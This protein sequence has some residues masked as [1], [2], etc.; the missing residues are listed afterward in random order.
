[1]HSDARESIWEFLCTFDKGEWHS[2]LDWISYSQGSFLL[3]EG[4]ETRFS[5]AFLPG[6]IHSCPPPSHFFC[7]V[8]YALLQESK[9]IGFTV[10]VTLTTG[11]CPY[12]ECK[13]HVKF[14][15]STA[16]PSYPALSA[17]FFRKLQYLVTCIPFCFY[18]LGWS[19]HL[20]IHHFIC[21][22]CWHQCAVLSVCWPDTCSSPACSS[23]WRWVGC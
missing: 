11:V 8:P 1:M 13:V 21:S 19:N 20:I 10:C 9:A 16:V 4:Q 7:S 6:H 23:S 17:A 15:Q 2:S 5:M 12:Q 18:A 22:S 14:Y 3:P